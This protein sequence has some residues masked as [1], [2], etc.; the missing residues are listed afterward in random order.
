[1][2]TL[3]GE[4]CGMHNDSTK[5]TIGVAVGICLVCSVLVSTA[6]VSLQKIQARNK[7]IDQL[8]NILIAADLL[9]KDTNVQKVFEENIKS[10]II[11]LKT[12]DTVPPEQYNDVLNPANFDI[13]ALSRDPQYS[14]IIPASEDIAQIKR[15][16]VYM[17]VYKVEQHGKLQKLIL[18]VYG[19]GLWSTLYGFLTLGNDLRTIQGITFYEQGETPGL[20][21]EVDNPRWQ[22]IWKGKEAFDKD[23]D[24]RIQVIKGVVDKS[25][26]EAKYEVDG[27]SSST[28][29]T[30]GVDH[31]VRFW[32]G[33][34]GYG[35]YF[36]K[37]R[38]EV[39]DEKV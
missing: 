31:L 35:P 29:T 24:L 18:S 2:P 32:L 7:K 27:L 5:K 25:S 37:L 39:L 3:K 12:G 4:L 23:W 22:H 8:K 38:E 28:I 17:V 1:M 6:A 16:P 33:E 20:G 10:E 36:K 11:D 14:Q 34:N 15:M 13:K 26:P 30:R 9:G 19:K 21:G